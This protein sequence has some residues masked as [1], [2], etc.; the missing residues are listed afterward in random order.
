MIS[1]QRHKIIVHC[2]F[3]S[4][5]NSNGSEQEIYI[6]RSGSSNGGTADVFNS[7][8][9]ADALALHYD[10]TLLAGCY[11]LDAT[12]RAELE[13]QQQSAGGSTSS[14]SSSEAKV[15][16]FVIGSTRTFVR[17]HLDQKARVNLLASMKAQEGRPRMLTSGVYGGRDGRPP[18][19]LTGG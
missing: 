13:T 12:H 6:K 16:A 2:C 3:F 15:E 1:T 7:R 4:N 14:S 17:S 19:D 11:Q 18:I 9:R 5:Q 8:D 10:A